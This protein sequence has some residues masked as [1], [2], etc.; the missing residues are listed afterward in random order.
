MA[1][2]KLVHYVEDLG[3]I[4]ADARHTLVYKQ[5]LKK[6]LREAG[7]RSKKILRLRVVNAS[8]VT[9]PY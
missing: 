3:V 2:E 7:L 6:A 1:G 8:R 4:T 9:I 5:I